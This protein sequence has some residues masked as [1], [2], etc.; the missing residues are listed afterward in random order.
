[1][2]IYIAVDTGK[3]NT[4][5][6]WFNENKPGKK[7][8]KAD[9]FRSVVSETAIDGMSTTNNLVIYRGIAY[10]VGGVD[11]RALEGN[12]SKLTDEHKLCIYTAIAKILN[13]LN[14]G[15]EVHEVHQID[16]SIN[17][18]LLDFRSLKDEY[19]KAYQGKDVD[20][21]L[22]NKK[23][24]F[25]INT[26]RLSYEG[27]GV[28]IRNIDDEASQI[29]IIDIGG[30]N[31]THI[32]FE[33][34][35]LEN[36]E[37]IPTDVEGFKP[38]KGQN[39]MTN[40]GVLTLLQQIASD[41]SDSYDV[42]INDIEKI[43]EGRLPKP[44]KFDEIFKQRAKQH[45]VSI[46]NQVQKYRLNPSFTTIIFSGGGSLLLK[47]QLKAAFSEYS[48]RISPDAQF[49]NAKGMLEKVLNDEA[50]TS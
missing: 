18:P 43:I 34:F 15:D 47:E 24:S 12:N 28:V 48:I 33:K 11:E 8:I 16:L 41:L 1:M 22:D 27:S 45:V 35:K 13:R 9:S 50:I 20:L 44:A 2:K 40:N 29:H 31:D 25:T 42:T 6:S 4:K 26:I 19:T 38:I 30:K 39:G 21:E 7:N 14:T 46:K 10:D 3:S 36:Q 23:I 32:S 37:G 49:D 17:V 5:F